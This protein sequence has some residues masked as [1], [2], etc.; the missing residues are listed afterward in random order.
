MKKRFVTL[1]PAGTNIDLL[2]DEGQIPY[3]LCRYYAIDAKIVTCHID[4]R[5]ANLDLVQG[6]GVEHFPYLINNALTGLIYILLN[7]KI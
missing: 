6:L 7:A 5:T 2:K 4:N 1:H 3:T